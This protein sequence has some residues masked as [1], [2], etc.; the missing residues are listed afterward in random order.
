M[1]DKRYEQKKTNGNPRYTRTRPL[2][3]HV[4]ISVDY[5]A[6]H[7]GQ[8]G[9]TSYDRRGKLIVSHEREPRRKSLALRLNI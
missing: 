5:E 2:A 9:A 8:G 7:S 4:I 3:E 6:Q 1:N